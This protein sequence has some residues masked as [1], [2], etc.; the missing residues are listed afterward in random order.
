M[1]FRAVQTEIDLTQE[2]DLDEFEIVEDTVADVA[3][4][5]GFRQELGGG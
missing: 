2:E 5:Y 4:R 3:A 1:V